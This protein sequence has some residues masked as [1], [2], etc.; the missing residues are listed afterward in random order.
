MQ[1]LYK[2]PVG[3]EKLLHRQQCTYNFLAVL[4][5]CSSQTDF[6]QLWLSTRFHHSLPRELPLLAVLTSLCWLSDL[7]LALSPEPLTAAGIRLA[8]N[9]PS[10][11]SLLSQGEGPPHL[12]AGIMWL[13]YCIPPGD[14]SFPK[15]GAEMR[16][17]SQKSEG[18]TCLNMRK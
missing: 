8:R 4:S 13:C 14:M 7:L 16:T 18:T 11:S 1:P 10:K 9:S 3:K 12:L 5:C 15:K 2:R 17:L 6:A